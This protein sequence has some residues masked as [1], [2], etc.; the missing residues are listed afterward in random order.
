MFCN[1]C[2]AYIKDEYR[3]CNHCGAPKPAPAPRPGTPLVPLLISGFM[4]LAGLL[5]YLFMR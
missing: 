4:F 1:H 5:T 3:F 2:G